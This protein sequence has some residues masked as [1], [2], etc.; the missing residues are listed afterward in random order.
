M[1]FPED[2]PVVDVDVRDDLRMGR[3][4]FARIMRAAE[5][6]KAGEVL[7]V[8]ALFAPTPLLAVLS[9]LGLAH[10]MQREADDDWSV[11]F[12]QSVRRG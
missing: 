3:E 11:W 9:E 8:R 4:P 12:W 7:R 2:A 5:S 6:L 10:H 1:E